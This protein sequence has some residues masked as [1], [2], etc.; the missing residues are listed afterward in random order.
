MFH[1][2][3]GD[4]YQSTTPPLSTG[5]KKAGDLYPQRYETHH[6]RDLADERYKKSPPSLFKTEQTPAGCLC[7]RALNND[8]L[9]HYYPQAAF[10][11]DFGFSFQIR[12]F[13]HLPQLILGHFDLTDLKVKGPRSFPDLLNH[14]I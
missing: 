8:L 11:E 13:Y 9:S 3:Y 6:A 7:G 1:G 10:G 5:G 12:R 14:C 2:G 4:L